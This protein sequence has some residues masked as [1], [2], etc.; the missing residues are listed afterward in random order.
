VTRGTGLLV[1][2]TAALALAAGA[3]VVGGA[4]VPRERAER[5]REFQSLVGG[6]GL[7]FSLDLSRGEFDFDPRVG[8]VSWTRLGAVPAGDAFAPAH[9]LDPPAALRAPKAR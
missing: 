6:L 5:G 2:T 7:G 3:V 8:A 1:A 9:H 4:S